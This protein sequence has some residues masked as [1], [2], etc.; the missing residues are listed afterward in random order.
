MPTSVNLVATCTCHDL[1]HSDGETHKLANQNNSTAYLGTVARIWGSLLIC[2][3]NSISRPHSQPRWNPFST[4]LAREITAH[5]SFHLLDLYT[6][7]RRPQTLVQSDRSAVDR[8]IPYPLPP[9]LGSVM[10]IARAPLLV[11]AGPTF[12]FSRERAQVHSLH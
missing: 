4:K 5:G 6:P 8:T 2:E 1:V 10:W 9:I 11:P 7:E 3:G 12:S